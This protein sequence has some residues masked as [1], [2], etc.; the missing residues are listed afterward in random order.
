MISTLDIGLNFTTNT[1]NFNSFLLYITAFFEG[2]YI[3]WQDA[4][5]ALEQTEWVAQTAMDMFWEDFWKGCDLIPDVAGFDAGK[6]GCKLPL[7]IFRFVLIAIFFA[8]HTVSTD[9]EINA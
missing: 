6:V 8:A 1:T 3:G 4:N 7:F 9:C 5:H 2:E